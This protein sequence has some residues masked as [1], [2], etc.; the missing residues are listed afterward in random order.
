MNKYYDIF[1][2]WEDVKKE[3]NIN[4]PEP[5]VILA[6]YTYEDYSGD[7]IIAFIEGEKIG[8]VTGGHCSCNGLEGQ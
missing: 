4:I 8:V 5:K 2:N 6:A 7:T 1:S 3:F